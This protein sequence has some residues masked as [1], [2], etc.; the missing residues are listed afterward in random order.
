MFRVGGAALS[1]ATCTATETVPDG[2]TANQAGC[3]GV[4]L[5]GS[6]TIT[7]TLSSADP[8]AGTLPDTQPAGCPAISFTPTTVPNATVGVAYSQQFT[9]SGGTSPYVFTT[10]LATLPAGLTL[11]TAGLLSGTPTVELAQTFNIRAT[12][13]VGCFLVRSYTMRFGVEVPTLPQVFTVML[14]FGLLVLGYMH[15]QRRRSVI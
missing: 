14:G 8:P 3:A 4:A 7:N 10:T 1:G 11:T 6:C 13:A 12:D 15:L 2:Y 5:N 9:G